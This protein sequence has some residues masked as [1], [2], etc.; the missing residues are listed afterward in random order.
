LPFLISREIKTVTQ[1]EMFGGIDKTATLSP[2]RKYRYALWRTWDKSKPYVM[3]IG[4][5]PSTANETEDDP[6]IRRCINFARDWGFG[7]LCMANL[8]AFRATKP[9]DMKKSPDPVGPENN[10]FLVSLSGCAGKVIAAW[11]NHGDFVGRERQVKSLIAKQIH[12]LGKNSNGSP[13]HPL[14]LKKDTELILY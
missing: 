2:D 14:Y 3:F 12:C 5:N 8:F 7:G 10:K 1:I 9:E 6:T 11:G 13:K 4:L